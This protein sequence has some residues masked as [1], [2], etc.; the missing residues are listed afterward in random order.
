MH[1]SHQLFSYPS[2]RRGDF[3]LF[4]LVPDNFLFVPLSDGIYFFLRMMWIFFRML[5]LPG[6]EDP[7]TPPSPFFQMV[8]LMS[9]GWRFRRNPYFSYHYISQDGITQLLTTQ[10]SPARPYLRF[11]PP[12]TVYVVLKNGICDQEPLPFFS[13]FRLKRFILAFSDLYDPPF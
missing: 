1:L 6:G 5:S 13:K 7:F 4:Y 2:E 9:C 3:F 11:D 8:W 12:F 10:V